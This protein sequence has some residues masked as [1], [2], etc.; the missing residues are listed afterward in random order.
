MKK[1]LIILAIMMAVSMTSS[2]WAFYMD[3]EEGLGNDGAN[4]VGIPGVTFTTSAGLPWVYGDSNTGSYNTHSVDLNLWFGSY[5]HYG[6]VFAW[7]G[8]S[9]NWGRID[10]TDQNGTWFQTGVCSASTFTADAYDDT[11]NIIDTA[12]LPSGN[13]GWPNVTDMAWLRVDAPVGKTISYIIMH[14]S[15]NYWEVDNM[16]GDMAGGTQPIP[17]PGTL[18]LLGAGLVGLVGYGKLRLQ[19]RKK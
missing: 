9:G 16:T 17:E 13:L 6:Y 18:L 15:G 2:S 14:D 7:L 11:D 5:N 4:I 10:F 8:V 12:T 3:F 19:R 1:L